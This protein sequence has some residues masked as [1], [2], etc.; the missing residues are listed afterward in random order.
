MKYEVHWVKRYY[1]TGTFVVNAD[2]ELEAEELGVELM[3][4]QEGSMQYEG[5]EVEF[6]EQGEE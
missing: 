2:S 5:G 1:V 6:V 4:D 3:G